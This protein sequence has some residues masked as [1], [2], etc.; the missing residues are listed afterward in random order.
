MMGL[1]E[2]LLGMFREDFEFN[3]DAV[4]S[5]MGGHAGAKPARRVQPHAEPEPADSQAAESRDGNRPR[6]RRAGR[7]AELRKIPFFVRGKA[8][9]NAEPSQPKTVCHR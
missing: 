6:S 8:R 7:G 2:H 1:E 3:D 9:R 5:H 4:P